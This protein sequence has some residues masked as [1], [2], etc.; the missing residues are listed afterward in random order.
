MGVTDYMHYQSVQPECLDAKLQDGQ[1]VS[2]VQCHAEGWLARLL[3]WQ[4]GIDTV[5]VHLGG[6]RQH[7]RGQVDRIHRVAQ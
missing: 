6:T 2:P 3:G 7:R 4:S 5:H 1:P